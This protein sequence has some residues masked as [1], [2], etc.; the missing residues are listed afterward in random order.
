MT[1]L[2]SREVLPKKPDSNP[3]IEPATPSQTRESTAV[4]G[5]NS[6]P[7]RLS[8]R[9]AS[10]SVEVDVV[11]E[12]KGVKGKRK[13]DLSDGSL[14][15]GRGGS[16]GVLNLR[17]GKKVKKTVVEN[18]GG[19][20]VKSLHGNGGDSGEKGKCSRGDDTE[21]G[22]ESVVGNGRR[23]LSREEKGKEKVVDEGMSGGNGS[24]KR[25]RFSREEKGKEKLVDE[26]FVDLNLQNEVKS[27]V[28]NRDSNVKSSGTNVSRME[29]F[30]DIA[31]QNA[32]RFAHFSS[33]EEED[34]H[35]PFENES[36]EIDDWPGPFSTAMKIIRDRADNAN[37]KKDNASLECKKKVPITWVPKMGRSCGKKLVV[38]SLKELCIKILVK[39]A[40]AITSLEHVPDALRHHLSHM[41]CDSRGMNSHFL[42][43]LVHG[44]PTEIRL[45]D[46]S[47]IT[48]EEFT[49]TFEGCDT[50]NLS[51]CS[52]AQ[53]DGFS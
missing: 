16:E 1:V 10:K 8:G 49:K 36:D 23:R 26:D 31:R 44:S 12:Q 20:S 4:N 19:E 38:P 11:S 34:D 39:N 22:K 27:S 15:L 25:M 47:W 53:N 37:S 46:C 33:Y 7:I 29:Q 32:S 5:V 18:G 35:V 24:E 48:E 52:F 41:L 43:L 42:N 17:S 9:L 14:I 13:L 50:S 51:V 2:R 45:R 6:V 30:R 28:E 40:D 21:N 3:S